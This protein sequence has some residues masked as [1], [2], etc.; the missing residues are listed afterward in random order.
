MKGTGTG[1]VEDDRLENGDGR[2]ISEQ[3]W[4]II[5]NF[6]PNR[7]KLNWEKICGVVGGR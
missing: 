4:N 6:V 1:T 5:Q 3:H 7:E 2:L